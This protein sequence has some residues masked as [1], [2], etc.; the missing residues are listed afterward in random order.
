[1]SSPLPELNA[2]AEH[3]LLSLWQLLV[4]L[5]SSDHFRGVRLMRQGCLRV[6]AVSITLLAVG[7]G[8][9]SPRP[10]RAE[11]KYMFLTVTDYEAGISYRQ[12]QW[13]APIAVSYTHLL[14][15]AIAVVAA[16]AIALPPASGIL[17]A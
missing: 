13:H 17:H 11:S 10:A 12:A 5:R 3:C 15:T 16:S 9:F 1:M 2:G 7:L 14:R 8:G 6:C 4:F